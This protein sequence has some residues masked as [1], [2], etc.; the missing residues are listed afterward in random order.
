[1]WPQ[2]F[3]SV[4]RNPHGKELTNCIYVKPGSALDKKHLIEQPE[5]ARFSEPRQR[6][7]QEQKRGQSEEKRRRGLGLHY[8][9]RCSTDP[10][11][12]HGPG[13]GS[14]GNGFTG[15]TSDLQKLPLNHIPW[16]PHTS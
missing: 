13:V 5:T 11:R 3:L 9:K 8:P 1:M 4:K 10:D 12:R 15:S 14:D 16:D 7:A 6:T 2:E